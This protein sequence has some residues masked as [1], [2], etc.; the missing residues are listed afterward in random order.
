ML[1]QRRL[2][3]VANNLAQVN[4][5]GYKTD[6]P[7]FRIYQ[8]NAAQANEFT[9]AAVDQSEW[10]F[11][12]IDHSQG[13]TQLTNNPLDLALNG[14]GFFVVRS[15]AGPRYTR[16]EGWQ[17]LDTKN[18]PIK[19]ENADIKNGGIFINESG[20]VVVNGNPIAQINIV[21]FQKPYPLEKKGFSSFAPI[22]D[23]IKPTTPAETRIQQGYLEG[24]NVNAVVEMTK[25]IEIGR[26]YETYQKMLQSFDQV[27]ETAVNELGE[28]HTI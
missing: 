12:H 26:L 15:P 7:V 2:E 20:H 23:S 11:T 24:S 6:V 10:R 8:S 25:L 22:D 1:Q 21:D 18:A 17:V 28:V 16:A 13:N 27:E 3:L 4:T 9:A 5:P 19:I 14:D